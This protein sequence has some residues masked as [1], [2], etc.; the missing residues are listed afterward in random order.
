[1][2]GKTKL[3]DTIPALLDSATFKTPQKVFRIY[4][5]SLVKKKKLAWWNNLIKS[6]IMRMKSYWEFFNYIS[7]SLGLEPLGQ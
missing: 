5:V 6:F 7:Y 1:V 4:F 2:Q 3:F